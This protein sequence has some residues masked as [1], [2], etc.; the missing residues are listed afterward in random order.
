VGTKWPAHFPKRGC[1]PKK[2]KPVDG[3]VFRRCGGTDEDWQS[4]LERNVFKNHP[5]NYRAALSCYVD[6]NHL[7]EIVQVHEEWWIAAA[8]LKPDHGVIAQYNKPKHYSL[9]LTRAALAAHGEL[10]RKL[11]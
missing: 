3:R 2:A 8:D 4:A 9:W 5:D 6:L 1:P 10:F 7:R 11:E